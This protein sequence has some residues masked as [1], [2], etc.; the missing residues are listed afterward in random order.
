MLK[1]IIT[2]SQF[3]KGGYGWYVVIDHGHGLT[4]R[5]AHHHVNKVKVGQTVQ[6]GEQIGEVGSTGRS[7]GP[8]LHFELRVHNQ[9]MNPLSFLPALP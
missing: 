8:H 1:G 4:S 7:S 3:N 9:S 5:Y 6:R 2:T